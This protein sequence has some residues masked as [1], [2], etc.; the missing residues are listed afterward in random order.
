MQLCLKTHG[1]LGKKGVLPVLLGC[2]SSDCN[3]YHQL[4]QCHNRCFLV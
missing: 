1:A 2:Q 3:V 4:G